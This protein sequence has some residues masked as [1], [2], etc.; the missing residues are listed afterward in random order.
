MALTTWS[1]SRVRKHDILVAKNYLRE[2]EVDTL[3]RLVVI[4]LEQ[5]ELRAKRQQDLTLDYWRSSVDRMLA[6][7]DQPLLDDPG[8]ISHESMKSIA[9]E[10]YETFNA[11]R[12]RQESI[13]A[14]AEDL[15]AIEELEKDLKEK[16]GKE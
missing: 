3:N 7:N 12:R 14:D 5:A 1:G 15:R 16:G 10:R 11:K 13:D 8:S 6:S 4:F 9:G 2:D